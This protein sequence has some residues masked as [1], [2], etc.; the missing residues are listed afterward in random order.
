MYG[1]LISPIVDAGK[2]EAFP[3]NLK[4]PKLLKP[5][6]VT[7]NSVGLEPPSKAEIKLLILN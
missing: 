3:K 6:T 4:S 1:T 5:F 2:D 7:L